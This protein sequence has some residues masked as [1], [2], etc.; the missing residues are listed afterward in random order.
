MPIKEIALEFLVKVYEIE[1]DGTLTFV[2]NIPCQTGVDNIEF[3]EDG[4]LWI[5][6]HPNLLRF[7]SY[8]KG[9]RETSPSEIIKIDYR[10]T[11][12]YTVEKIY[13]ANG[14]D[15]SAS[16]VAATYG[17]LILTGNVMDENFLILK[18]NGANSK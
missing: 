1:A 13:V 18:R 6:S 12:D 10:D 15:M 16:T 2:K 14:E 4:N 8:A 11:G 3:D 5:G 17:N 7:S 9:K